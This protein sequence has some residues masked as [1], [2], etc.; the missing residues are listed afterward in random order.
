MWI[1]RIILPGAET[2]QPIKGGGIAS[3]TLAMT[4]GR[5]RVA[6]ARGGTGGG[7]A[8]LALGVTRGAGSL[9]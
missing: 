4:K 8:L 1:N 5:D 6:G 9:R 3:L 2:R 7:V